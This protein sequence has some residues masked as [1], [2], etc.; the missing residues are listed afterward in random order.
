[1]SMSGWLTDQ[2]P[3]LGQALSLVLGLVSFCANQESVEDYCREQCIE[4]DEFTECL[5]IVCD[6]VDLNPGVWEM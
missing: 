5:D 6:A 2:D 1:M 3:E 4:V